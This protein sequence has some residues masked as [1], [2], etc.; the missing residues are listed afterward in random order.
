[1]GG[2][3]CH[4]GT[5]TPLRIQRNRANEQETG[6]RGGNACQAGDV[7]AHMSYRRAAEVNLHRY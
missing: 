2:T 1:M 5:S 4:K 7:N 3:V 6:E